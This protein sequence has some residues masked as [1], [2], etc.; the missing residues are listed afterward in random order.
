MITEPVLCACGCGIPTPIATR[1]RTA[2]KQIK[3]VALR[4]ISGHNTRLIPPEEQ[5]RRSSFNDGSAIRYTGSPSNYI[6]LNSRHMHRVVMEQHLGRP[7]LSTEI[8]HHIDNNK[9]NNDISNLE[10]MSQADH[11]RLHIKQR[12]QGQ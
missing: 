12:R 5:K 7:L 1:T 3:G 9:W 11:I 8:V 2:R 10:V 6:K 4:F